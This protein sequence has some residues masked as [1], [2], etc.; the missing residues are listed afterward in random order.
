[1]HSART[2]SKDNR[3]DCIQ[4][5]HTVAVRCLIVKFLKLTVRKHIQYQTVHGPRIK[6]RVDGLMEMFAVHPRCLG[7]QLEVNIIQG[8]GCLGNTAEG[9]C[10]EKL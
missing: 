8:P 10:S 3:F 4:R 1:M 6:A 2:P 7:K 5:C 9:Q